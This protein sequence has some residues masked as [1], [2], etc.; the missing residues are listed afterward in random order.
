[1]QKKP[2]TYAFVDALKFA[3]I[4]AI[5][6][7]HAIQYKW[8]AYKYI[9]NACQNPALIFAS[10]LIFSFCIVDLGKYR[11]F[12]D[13]LNKK[14]HRLMV[15]Y[16]LTAFLYYLPLRMAAS[17]VTHANDVF[18]GPIFKIGLV[19]LM[20][21]QTDHLWF[22]YALFLM[23]LII[24]PVV[25]HKNFAKS[26]PAQIAL[27]FVAFVINLVGTKVSS[28][29][30]CLQQIMLYSV[31]FAGGYL[32]N[33]HARD[34]FG[35]GKKRLRV[36]LLVLSV[37]VT[38][39][40]D[41]IDHRVGYLPNMQYAGSLASSLLFAGMEIL[42]Q[43]GLIYILMVAIQFLYEKTSLFRIP[44]IAYLSKNS[45][46]IY[47]FHQ[48]LVKVFLKLLPDVSSDSANFFRSVCAATLSVIGALVVSFTVDRAYAFLKT[49]MKSQTKHTAG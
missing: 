36:V 5:V 23:Y 21:E 41:Y 28:T 27:M 14:A 12:R 6:L 11:T 17:I 25:S 20:G 32:F 43:F 37:I 24:Y 4:M 16:L 1:M 44:C 10:G 18:S 39:V 3:V 47:L 48:P 40:V 19:F 42:K 35:D 30:F 38:A 29:V 34:L 46:N 22:I 7:N 33:L 26:I 2:N 13:V 15:P 31:F 49:K 9:T 45:F 8:N